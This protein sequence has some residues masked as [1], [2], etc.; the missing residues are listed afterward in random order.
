MVVE[1][2]CFQEYNIRVIRYMSTEVS[3]EYTSSIFKVENKQG[4]KLTRRDEICPVVFI[5]IT[6]IL[7]IYSYLFFEPNYG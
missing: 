2:R 3:G 5:I 4:K 6:C 7:H 1:E